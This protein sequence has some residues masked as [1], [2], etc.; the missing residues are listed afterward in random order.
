MAIEPSLQQIKDDEA[1]A[2]RLWREESGLSDAIDVAESP[3]PAKKRKT[4]CSELDPGLSDKTRPEE[5]EL[6]PEVHAEVEELWACWLRGENVQNNPV[7]TGP[8]IESQAYALHAVHALLSEF[9]KVHAGT[10]RAAFK[11]AG[12][13][14]EARHLLEVDK[15]FCQET[16]KSKRPLKNAPPCAVPHILKKEMELGRNAVAISKALSKRREVRDARVEALRAVGGLGTCGCCFDDELLP[17]EELRCSAAEGHGFCIA[18]VKQSALQFFG[19]G[20]FTLNLTQAVVQAS[21]PSSASSSSSSSSSN[22]AT[23]ATMGLSC[24]ELRCMHTSGCAGKF[25]DS[26]LRH[27]LPVKD[28][29]RYSRR[30]AALQ[31]AISG[32]QD[33]VACPACDFMV[34]MSDPSDG[35]V[36]CLD[37]GCGK[38]SCRWCRQDEHSPLRCDQVEKDG[39]T[40][41]RTFLEERMSAAA[42]KRCPNPKCGKP[43]ERIEG[44]NHMRCPCGTHSCY[45]CGK[46]LDKKRP[47]DHYKDGHLGG[48]KNAA[49]SKCVVYGIPEWAKKEEQDLQEEAHKALEQYLKENPDLQEVAQ[50]AKNLHLWQRPRKKASRFL[51]PSSTNRMCVM[52]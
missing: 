48:G 26:A 36:R 42:L 20:L 29:V 52:Q 41:I 51:G 10:V 4:L 24:T 35:V 11:Q 27:A 2:R 7:A 1:F 32:L 37:P 38:V 49:N 46:E 22:A 31:A 16:L 5:T 45:L 43:Y 21:E 18:C 47:Y 39:E 44:C 8:E 15:D 40:K 19:S 17:E 9:R 14:S 30:S 25:S 34:Q 13:Y 28:Y 3:T 33:L 23:A 50:Q 6:P 12:T